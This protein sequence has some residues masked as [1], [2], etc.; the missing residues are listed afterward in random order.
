M[1]NDPFFIIAIVVI[2]V[3]L[4]AI[5]AAIIALG[6][7]PAKIARKRNHPQVDA[8]NAASWIGLALAGVGWPIAFVWAFLRKPQNAESLE[9]EATYS[10][11]ELSELKQRLELV[12]NQLASLS[13]EATK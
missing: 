11:A 1:T 10:K 3:L 8:I 12:E 9:Y 7:L 13:K 6:S 5:A 2:T 4:L